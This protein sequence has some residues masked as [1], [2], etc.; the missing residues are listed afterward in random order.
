MQTLLRLATGAQRRHETLAMKCEL[1][2]NHTLSKPRLYL[3]LLR[4]NIELL[5]TQIIGALLYSNVVSTQKKLFCT[6]VHSIYHSIY[7]PCGTKFLR[8]FNFAD[9]RFFVFCVN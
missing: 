6:C 4:T 5:T 3:R 9:W 8:K 2:Q 7:L 1:L